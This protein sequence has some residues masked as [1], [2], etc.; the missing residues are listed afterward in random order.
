MAV[1]PRLPPSPADAAL[2]AVR[3]PGRDIHPNTYPHGTTTP[4][5][6]PPYKEIRVPPPFCRNPPFSSSTASSNLLL[7]FFL[8]LSSSPLLVVAPPSP[9]PLPASAR[10]FSSRKRCSVGPRL[11][12]NKRAHTVRATLLRGLIPP[13]VHRAGAT[14]QRAHPVQPLT[15]SNKN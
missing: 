5:S 15:G 1:Q 4:S 2:T 12:L 6:P 3:P 9:P 11:A 8:F 7:S 13:V 14:S 10:S